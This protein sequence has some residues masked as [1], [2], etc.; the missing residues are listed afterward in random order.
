MLQVTRKDISMTRLARIALL[1]G[2]ALG[3]RAEIGEIIFEYGKGHHGPGSGPEEPPRSLDPEC[4]ERFESRAQVVREAFA[5]C[6]T[7][8]DCTFVEGPGCL[9][10]FLCTSAVAAGNEEEYLSS[11][12]IEIDEYIQECGNF[13][14]IADC[15][16]PSEIEPACDT[17]TGLCTARFLE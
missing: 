12:Q 17:S 5:A 10:A 6:E 2:L 14:S 1:L 8:A 13:C 4:A 11:A 7:D 9:S 15:V 16:G 3:C